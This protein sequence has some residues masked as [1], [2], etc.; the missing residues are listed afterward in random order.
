MQLPILLNMVADLV[1]AIVTLVY[2]GNALKFGWPRQWWCPSR[3][4]Y[5]IPPNGPTWLPADA[6]CTRF[7]IPARALIGAIAGLGFV[8]GLV[9]SFLC[10]HVC[11]VFRNVVDLFCVIRFVFLA[12]LVLRIIVVSRSKSWRN[13]EV[14]ALGEYNVQFTFKVTRNGEP[15]G[16]MDARGGHVQ[17]HESA[18]ETPLIET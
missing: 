4:V 11:V 8:L 9:L 3:Y 6:R 5:P 17:P 14:F 16:G 15:V 10:F 13:S 1:L 2:A 7:I 12:L 18:V